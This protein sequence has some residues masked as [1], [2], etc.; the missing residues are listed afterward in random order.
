MKAGAGVGLADAEDSRQLGVA[1]LAV[2]LQE[3]DSRSVGR[4][5]GERGADDVAAL[6]AARARRPARRDPRAV[7]RLGDELK[8]SACAVAA[9][10]VEG[11]VAGDGEEQRARCTA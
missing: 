1:E 4:S 7:G 11:G 2:E 6:G 9:Q 3:D 5:V 8:S 10:L